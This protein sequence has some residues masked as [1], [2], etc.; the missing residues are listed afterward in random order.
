M[1]TIAG[2]MM[3]LILILLG[4]VIWTSVQMYGAPCEEFSN[5]S[6]QNLPARCLEFYK[7]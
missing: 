3:T 7:K 5:V 2:I 6:I 1:G 4:F